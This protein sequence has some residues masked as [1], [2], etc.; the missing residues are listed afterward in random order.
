V[1]SSAVPDDLLVKASELF[2]FSFHFICGILHNSGSP[3]M[4]AWVIASGV[5]FLYTY[6]LWFAYVKLSYWTAG[7]LVPQY[8]K[9]IEGNSNYRALLIV[10]H[11]ASKNGL[12][13]L[14]V[15]AVKI[16]EHVERH[17]ASIVD[18]AYDALRRELLSWLYEV[19][20]FSPSLP[21]VW[22]SDMRKPIGTM[23]FLAK[24]LHQIHVHKQGFNEFEQLPTWVFAVADR[25]NQR[26]LS[27]AEK[28]NSMKR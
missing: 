16:K 21:D 28:L 8:F 19:H 4:N 18:G 11:D 24:Q 14:D 6:A 26:T 5:V 20:V 22:W 1:Y 7:K 10:M 25:A 2:A 23:A 3:P 27:F 12:T 17:N 13:D 15:C 9:M